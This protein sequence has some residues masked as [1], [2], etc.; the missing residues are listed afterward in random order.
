MK[1]R[2][3]FKNKINF[4]DIF[5]NIIKKEYIIISKFKENTFDK[6]KYFIDYN[7]KFLLKKISKN[8]SLKYNILVKELNIDNQR[9]YLFI[10]NYI[11]QIK[12]NNQLYYKFNKYTDIFKNEKINYQNLISLI[13]DD[14]CVPFWNDKI[15]KISEEIFLPIKKNMEKINEP[16]TFDSKSWF[17]TEHFMNKNDCDNEILILRER[18]FNNIIKN[19]KTGEIQNIV[20]TRKIKIYFNSKQ[21]QCLE[22]IYGAYR[23]FYNRAIQYINNYNKTDMKTFY[24]INYNDLKSKRI[25]SLQDVENKFSYITMRKHIKDNYP[26]WMED[27]QIQSHLIDEAF[28]EASSNYSKCLEKYKKY[29]IPFKLK[30]KTKKDKYQTMNIEKVM[31]NK[32]TNTL[33]PG[34]KVKDVNN[35]SV[36]L[37]SNLKLFEKIKKYN[38]SDSSISC[39]TRLN[40]YYLNLNYRDTFTKNQNILKNKRVCAIDIG[41]KVFLSVYSDN[42]VDMIGS[43]INTRMLKICKEIDIITSRINKKKDKKFYYNSNKRRNMKKALHRKI[44]YLENIKSELHNK[45]IRYLTTNFGKIIIPPFDTQGMAGKFNSKLARSLY[46]LSY[47]KFES[48]LK[49]RCNEYDIDL[50]IR[51]EYYTSKTCTKCGCIKH[52]L[53]LS[54]RIYKCKS[55]GLK[56]DRDVNASRNILLRNN[57]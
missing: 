4:F 46:N 52:D 32:N 41:I 30:N 7:Y 40:E 20:K 17:K 55:C 54:D 10:K 45:C 28:K 53:K 47:Y 25:I 13:K 42:H 9:I 29:N 24:L 15:K 19:K 27:I 14:E 43:E 50:V 51:P 12:I 3:K 57:F 34:I 18:Q 37:F 38:M 36:S 33:F 11:K 23:Y 44:K 35:K 6:L 56:I 8:D 1:K 21:K 22:R 2:K 39:N 16:I 49:N 31:F 26:K 48:K 5:D